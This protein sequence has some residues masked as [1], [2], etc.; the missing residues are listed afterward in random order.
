VIY[1]Y[2]PETVHRNV[3]SEEKGESQDSASHVDE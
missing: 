1:R 3:M 2:V